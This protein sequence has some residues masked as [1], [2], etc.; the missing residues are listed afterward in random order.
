MSIRALATRAVG[1]PRR[2]GLDPRFFLCLLVAQVALRALFYLPHL[3]VGKLPFLVALR[4]LSL[5]GPLYIAIRG[6]GIA[7]ILNLSLLL[8]WSLKTAWEVCYFVFL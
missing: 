3:G 1:I 4:G 7:P 2:H 8:G 6:R 5:V